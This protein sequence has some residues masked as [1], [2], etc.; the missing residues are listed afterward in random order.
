MIFSLTIYIIM[1]NW[2][3]ALE[4]ILIN[5]L[6]FSS[7]KSRFIFLITLFANSWVLVKLLVEI[8]RLR[9]RLLF[10]LV[11]FLSIIRSSTIFSRIIYLKFQNL[12]IRIMNYTLN[13]LNTLTSG[14][15]NSGKVYINYYFWIIMVR[16]LRSS[17]SIIVKSVIS[18]F[19]VYYL[20][21]YIFVNLS[22]S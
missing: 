17:L 1:I 8:V 12:V 21:L 5:G 10:F 9:F 13:G 20:T 3:F 16:I 18:F 11:R 15:R 22:M 2:G 14:A 7:L 4:S 6:L 19:S